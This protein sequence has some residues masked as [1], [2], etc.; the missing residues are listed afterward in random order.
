[1]YGPEVDGTP[2]LKTCLKQS[3]KAQHPPAVGLNGEE[4]S[5][6]TLSL[7]KV[8]TVDFKRPIRRQ[9][10]PPLKL[11]AYDSST[12]TWPTED[13]NVVKPLCLPG[14]NIK[15]RIADSVITRTDVHVIAISPSRPGIGAPNE[16]AQR[17]LATPTMQVV[18]SGNGMYGAVWDDEN[19]KNS[20]SSREPI[21]GEVSEAT[22]VSFFGLKRINT[23]LV[24]WSWIRGLPKDKAKT[25]QI[26]VFADES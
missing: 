14:S 2:P 15:S 24:E 20:D 4:Y 17:Q 25:V 1:M 9:S 21:T 26:V 19:F 6:E 11:W 13:L 7:R 12:I 18:E 22:S 5:H 16:S 3:P 23:Q 10:L 8:K